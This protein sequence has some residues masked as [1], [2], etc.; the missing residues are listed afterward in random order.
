MNIMTS[1]GRHLRKGFRCGS[2]GFTLVEMLV[3]LAIVSIMAALLLSALS[4]FPASH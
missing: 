1:S 3:V 2:P 4:K